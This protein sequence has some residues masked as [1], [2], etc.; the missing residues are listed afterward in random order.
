[1]KKRY[2]Y[3]AVFHY[4]DD[5]IS[6][7]FP[8]LPGCLPCAQTTEEA[9][10]NAKEAMGLHLWGMEQDDEPIPDPTPIDKIHLEKNEVPVLIE[11]FMPTIRDKMKTRYVKKTLS[12]PAWLASKAD[13]EGVNFSKV[14]QSALMDYLD[15]NS[16]E[17][18]RA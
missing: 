18:K 11:V 13:E 7:S 3:I 4:D 10:K 15:V 5:G 2:E 1:M 6:I 8:D 17:R 9:M 16:D 12:L 14:F